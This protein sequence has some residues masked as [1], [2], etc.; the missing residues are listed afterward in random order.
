MRGDKS[1]LFMKEAREEALHFG[2]RQNGDEED[3]MV[4]AWIYLQINK[5]NIS[6]RLEIYKTLSP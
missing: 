3:L 4:S 2:W 6:L 1:P 5:I